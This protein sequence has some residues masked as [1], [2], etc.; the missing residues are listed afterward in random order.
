M[1]VEF[2]IDR[3]TSKQKVLADIIWSFEEFDQ[4]EKFIATLGSADRMECES[5]IELMKMAAVEQCYEG[6]SELEEAK[7]A[8]QKYVK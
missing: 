8:L 3:L 6:I 5:L 4:V 2:T 7:D 1:T